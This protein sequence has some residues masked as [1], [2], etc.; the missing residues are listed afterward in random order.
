MVDRFVNT[1]HFVEYNNVNYSKSYTLKKD[2]SSWMNL[3][4]VSPV[5]MH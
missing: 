4:A 3:L 1:I 2:E 5:V